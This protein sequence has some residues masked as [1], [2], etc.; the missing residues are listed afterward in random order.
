MMNNEAAAPLA[1]RPTLPWNKPT[2]MQAMLKIA[3]DIGG[4]VDLD[5]GRRFPGISNAILLECG[6]LL[7]AGTRSA[8]GIGL[9]EYAEAARPHGFDLLLVRNDGSD[10][11]YDIR[12]HQSGRWMTGYQRDDSDGS[13]RLCPLDNSDQRCIKVTARGLIV[14]QSADLVD[15]K[16]YGRSEAA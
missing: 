4:P 7:I 10:A 5:P 9:F 3:A 1:C 14:A 15:R 8:P 6:R 13:L 12:H 11:T 16:V 2:T